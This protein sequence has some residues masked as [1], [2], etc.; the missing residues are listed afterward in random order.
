MRARV[1]LH[2]RKFGKDQSSDSP[3][4]TMAMT[5][6]SRFG[7]AVGGEILDATKLTRFVKG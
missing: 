2:V 4:Q 5:F 6:R 7:W 1:V 3:R